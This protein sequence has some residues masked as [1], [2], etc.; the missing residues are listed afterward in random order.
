M[1]GRVQMSPEG[2]LR[3]ARNRDTPSSVS[4]RGGAAPEAISWYGRKAALA[5]ARDAQVL[6]RPA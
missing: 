6:T 3:V 4:L 1:L 5:V 2:M